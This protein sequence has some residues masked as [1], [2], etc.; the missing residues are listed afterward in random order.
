MY[1]VGDQR[2]VSVLFVA[3]LI[4]LFLFLKTFFTTCIFGTGF[5]AGLNCLQ[6]DHVNEENDGLTS[7]YTQLVASS[8]Q[9]VNARVL[10]SLGVG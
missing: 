8:L 2:L 10:N 3:V 4:T 6:V 9:T 5:F 7:I 1:C